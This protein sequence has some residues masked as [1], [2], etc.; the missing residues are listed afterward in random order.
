M[1]TVSGVH[2]Q[3]IIICNYNML[4]SWVS[5][6]LLLGCLFSDHLRFGVGFRDSVSTA[7]LQTVEHLKM[8]SPRPVES[9]AKKLRI[10]RR[11]VE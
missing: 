6:W 4:Y 10:T 7:P 3:V 1:Y 11:I 8:R 2:A 9:R 5:S